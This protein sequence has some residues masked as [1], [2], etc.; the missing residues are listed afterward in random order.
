MALFILKLGK[1]LNASSK[2]IKIGLIR[3]V[4]HDGTIDSNLIDKALLPPPISNCISWEISRRI[5]HRTS[6]DNK[7]S[8]RFP[9]D[10][11]KLRS[12]G[13]FDAH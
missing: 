13:S 1:Y 3:I 8:R 4:I 12:L 2:S 6:L 10:Y 5:S 9:C 7:K 11:G